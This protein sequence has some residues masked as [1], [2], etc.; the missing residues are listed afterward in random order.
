MVGVPWSINGLM[1]NGNGRVELSLLFYLTPVR[2]KSDL[3]HAGIR[4][5]AVEHCLRL[6]AGGSVDASE[7]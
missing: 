2:W 5:G 6:K 4:W 3:L 7:R 1:I